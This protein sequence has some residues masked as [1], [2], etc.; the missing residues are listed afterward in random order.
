VAT[1]ELEPNL[2]HAIDGPTTSLFLGEEQF[3]NALARLGASRD[4]LLPDLAA[5]KLAK[6]G[7]EID[8]LG[9]GRVPFD[10]RAIGP[11]SEGARKLRTFVMEKDGKASELA[12]MVRARAKTSLVASCKTNQVEPW[13]YLR[14]VF[15]R[16]PA[17]AND[18]PELIDHLLPDRWLIDHP[19]HRW[20]IDDLRR[21]ARR[22][23]AR[24]QRK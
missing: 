9:R 22:P 21:K 17:L 5:L 20:A 14:D 23:S 8:E 2:G 6:V 1:A 18:S 19:Q 10:L 13:A 16:L 4:P 3:L 15:S 12:D 24:G 7:V 11:V